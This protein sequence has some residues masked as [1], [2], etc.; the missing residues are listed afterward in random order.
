[1]GRSIWRY[2]VIALD[3]WDDFI[4]QFFCDFEEES[5][6]PVLLTFTTGVMPRN[7]L[8]QDFVR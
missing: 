6:P 3:Q 1:M 7:T 5:V 8:D 2:I 4:F